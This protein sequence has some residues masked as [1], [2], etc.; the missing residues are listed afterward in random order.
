MFSLDE[1]EQA[2]E[3]L[4]P[5]VLKTPLIR[6]RALEEEFKL[7]HRLF[8]K[9]EY[10]QLTG[11]FKARGAFLAC[12]ALDK[13]VV[14]RSSG[15]FGIA[16]AK[17]AK[18]FALPAHIVL[19]DKITS[20]KKNMIEKSSPS[21]YF[22]SSRD[23]EEDLVLS[24]AEKYSL[25]PI[26]PYDHKEVIKGQATLGLE[27]YSQ[28]PSMKY[29][30][31]P[32]GGGGLMAG[33]SLAIK[34]FNKDI[35]AIGVEPEE[36][37]DYFLSRKRKNRVKLAGIQTICEGLRAPTVG[38]MTYPL[39]EKYVDDVLLVSD[40][41]TKKVLKVFYEKMGIVLEPSGAITAGIFINTKRTFK[42]DTVLV[43]SG[44]NI[45]KDK[46]LNLIGEDERD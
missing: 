20:Y 40:T 12:L 25:S 46:F 30:I 3:A 27:I 44:A 2:A 15:N 19:S 22:C 34:S 6:A 10:L 32:I 16:V 29:F 5:Y 8:L 11:S 31:G 41:D 1:I 4:A 24:L 13:G 42:G 38:E 17:A 35:C 7:E 28:L 43:L 9:C 23:E 33:A 37:N 21:L 36:G 45:D 39:L 14:T 26:S 18:A